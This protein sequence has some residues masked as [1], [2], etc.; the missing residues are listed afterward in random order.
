[1]F[2]RD[3][4]APP[5]VQGEAVGFVIWGASLMAL[6]TW[7]HRLGWARVRANREK[8]LAPPR[9]SA[10]QKKWHWQLIVGFAIFLV[11]ANVAAR[12]FR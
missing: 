7:L 9:Y 6:G 11:L 8:L 4:P 10:A 1:V 5:F 2:G 12:V 3:T